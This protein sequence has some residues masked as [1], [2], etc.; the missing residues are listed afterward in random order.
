VGRGV[1]PLSQS[2]TFRPQGDMVQPVFLL[3][4]EP[5]EIPPPTEILNPR[6]FFIGVNLWTSFRHFLP[7]QFFFLKAFVKKNC[8][9]PGS[10]FQH[11]IHQNAYRPI[12]LPGLRWG[13]LQSSPRLP[14]WFSGRGNGRRRK[15]R[16][17]REG[18]SIP[19]LLFTIKHC[20]SVVYR[21]IVAATY[22]RS[23]DYSLCVVHSIAIMQIDCEFY[24]FFDNS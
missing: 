7:I 20:T 19:P 8:L 1:F 13:K 5:G 4:I 10:I 15:R 24:L 23:L 6:K 22:A 9:P 14:N 12:M 16:R 17:N 18:D 3:D 2:A 11:E 21:P